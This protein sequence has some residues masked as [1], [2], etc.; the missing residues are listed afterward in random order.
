[1]SLVV[2]GVIL[3]FAIPIISIAALVM[4]LSV[5][6]HVRRLERRIAELDTRAPA[7]A[8]STPP[9]RRRLKRLPP[10]RNHPPRSPRPSE[11]LSLLQSRRLLWPHPQRPPR[12]KKN[13]VRSGW[14]G[15]AA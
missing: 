14:S 9:L 5:R 2:I 8:I 7:T 3:L 15:S 13:S 12:W 10:S 11:H 4:T 6:D 1:M